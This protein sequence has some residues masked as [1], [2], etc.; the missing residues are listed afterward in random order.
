MKMNIRDFSKNLFKTLDSVS[1]SDPLVIT[2][3]GEPYILITPAT[4][5]TTDSEVPN[6][7]Y[8]PQ[9]LQDLK[10]RVIRLEKLIEDALALE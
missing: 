8:G 4:S 9:D 7:H 2:K 3:Y 10:K 6:P 5:S 1:P